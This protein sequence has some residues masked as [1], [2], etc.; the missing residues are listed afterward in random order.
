MQVF[1]YLTPDSIEQRIAAILWEKR[2]LFDDI[3]EN[4][5][6]ESLRRLDLRTLL[7]VVDSEPNHGQAKPDWIELAAKMGPSAAGRQ[8]SR[9]GG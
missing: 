2:V 4:V 9:G 6:T 5:A 7:R 3:I 1:S 8:G